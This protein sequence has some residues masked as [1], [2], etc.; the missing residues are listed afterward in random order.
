M[1][2]EAS[3]HTTEPFLIRE[4][5]L[6]EF[7]RRVLAQAER[8]RT[9]LLERV[10]YI[11]IVSELIDEIYQVRVAGLDEQVEAGFVSRSRGGI[12]AS[13]LLERIRSVVSEICEE[14]SAVF[15]EEV[16][17]ALERV[18]IR[19]LFWN[20]LDETDREYLHNVFHEQVYPVLTPLAVDPAHPFPYISNLSMNLAIMV[21]EPET[22]IQRF[23]RVKVPPILPGSSSCLKRGDSSRSNSSSRHIY[24][25]CSPGWTLRSAIR[26]G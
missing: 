6:L 5:S 24:M 14:Q 19:I 22:G 4:L 26:S 18:G 13:E 20:M 1:V 15:R 7:V 25:N 10:R 2:T 23:A 21:R 17:P 11:A 8:E 9:P 12:T 3:S 16:Q